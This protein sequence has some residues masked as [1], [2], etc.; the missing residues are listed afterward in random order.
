[1]KYKKKLI[2]VSLPLE[3]IN[4]ASAKEKSIRS[5]HPSTLH[6]WWARRPLASARAVIFA[7]MVDDPSEHPDI[8]P[9]EKSQQKER[10]RLFKIIEELVRWENNSNETLLKRAQE[11]I[12]QSWRHTCAENSDNPNAKNIFDRYKLP[13]FHDPF[14]GGGALPLEAQRLGLDSFASDLNPVAILINKAM[15]E[16]PP[17]FSNKLPVNP[18]AIN[19]KNLLESEWKN[20]KGLASD[21]RFYGDLVR[22]EAEKKLSALYP[23]IVITPEL[24]LERPDLAQFLNKKLNVIAWIWARTVKSS[25][26]AFAD[27]HV[28]LTSTF[29]LSTKSGKEAY[30]EPIIN[31]NSY[32]FKVKTGKP[33]DLVKTKSGTKLAR[34]ANFY[35]LLS[36]T[37]MSN[38]YVR[39]EFKARRNSDR[40]M[41]IVAESDSGRV[42]LSPTPE[43]ELIA[44]DI[45]PDWVPEQEMNQESSNLVSGRGYGITHWSDI[46]TKRQLSALSVF[47]KLISDIRSLIIKDALSAGLKADE[48]GIN[49]GGTGALAYAQAV[50]LYLAFAV[51]KMTDRNSSVCGWDSSRDSIRGVFGRQA[52]PMVWDFAESNPIGGSAGSYENAIDQC[53]RVL[54]ELPGIGFGKVEQADAATQSMSMNKVISTDPPYYDNIA[55]A[56]LSD[57]FYI[58]LRNSL[59]SV[60]PELFSTLTVPKSE[61]LVATPYRHGSAEK[62][63]KFFLDGMT[64]AMHRISE[65]AHEAFPVTIYYAFK[66]SESDGDDGTINTGW[67]TFLA[68]VIKAGFA[69]SGTWPMRTEL[70]NRMIGSGTNALASSIVLVCRKIPENAGIATRRD[71]IAALKD[72]LPLALKH[73]QAGNIAPVDLAQAAIGP[74]MAVYTRYSKVIDAEGN[75][76][77]VRTALALINQILDDALAE[78]EGDFD[79]DSRWAL[80]WFDQNGFSESDYGLAEQLSIARNTS[81]DGLEAGGIIMSKAGKVRLLKP[82]ELNEDWNPLLDKRL[83]TWEIVHQLIRALEIDGEGAA[84]KL[85]ANLGDYAENA[86]ELCYRLYALCER[87]KRTSEAISYNSLVQSWPEIVRLSRDI[88]R[89]PK[90]DEKDLFDQE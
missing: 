46:F 64:N 83:T 17:I 31:G 61:E 53:Y 25:N 10:Q 81:V 27:V 7:Q 71:F 66:Q 58:W 36:N 89:P 67:D 54:N 41:A 5:G 15:I 32:V 85:V 34:G 28:P 1:M 45:I 75:P 79:S 72:E 74:G 9:T 69:I 35:C 4:A 44:K 52:I 14:A 20:A 6:L 50:S 77:S 57:F 13:A 39:S 37:P 29:M 48:I 40:L 26:P 19:Q 23:K 33:K 49:K 3:A 30:V 60:F 78:Q 68:A 73:L 43:Q 63:E 24:I 76:I 87:K 59:K 80:T 84:A 51:D 65:Q 8:F 55:Y 47:S 56:D 11:E 38:E 22:S 18:N 21:V 88:S 12:K 62:A 16:I 42:Y 82:N 2:E 90:F 70:S 86:R